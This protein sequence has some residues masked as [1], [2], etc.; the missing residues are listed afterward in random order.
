MVL[1]RKISGLKAAEVA[2]KFEEVRNE[3][4]YQ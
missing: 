2:L 4:N 1:R 3:R